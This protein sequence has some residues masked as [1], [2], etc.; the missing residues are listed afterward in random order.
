[1]TQVERHSGWQRWSVLLPALAFVGGAALGGVVVGV[2]VGGGSSSSSDAAAPGATP[3][4]TPSA[5]RADAVVR[6]PGPCLQ[7]ADRADDAYALVQQ[8]VQAARD[9]DA[10]ALADLVDQ[11]QQQRPQVQAL[12]ADCRAAAADTVL[13]PAPTPARTP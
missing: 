1:M 9:L 4:P 10:R 2:A 8:G 12:I 11:V 3:T 7:A 13:Q 5:G 6:V